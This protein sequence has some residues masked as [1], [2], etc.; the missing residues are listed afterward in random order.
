MDTRKLLSTTI[1]Y[2]VADVIVMAVGGFLLLPLYTRA[3]SQAEFGIYVIVRANIEIFTY[4]LYLGL[5]SAVSRLYFDYKKKNQHIE[6]LSSV[7]MFFL[8]NLVVF[9]VVLSVWGARLWTMLSPATP[10]EPYLS[11]CLAIAAV[12]FFATLGALW[13]RMESRVTAFAGLQVGT[14]VV[15]AT[16]AVINLVVLD[17][18]LPGLLFALLI[19]S[20]CSALVLPWL[21]GR[22]FRPM[23]RWAHITESLHY[24]VPIVIGYV[25]YFVLNRVSTLIL[26]RHV[27]VDQVAIFGLAQQLAMSVSIASAALGKAIQP[28]VFGAEPRHA[29]VLL[30]KASLV[31]I[32]LMFTLTCLILL[33]SSDIVALAAPRSYQGL[34]EILLIL[35]A[36][37]FIYTLSLISDTALL[38]YRRPRISA[39]VSITGAGV[40][41]ILGLWLVPIHGIWGAAFAMAGAFCA[42]TV[43]G[44]VLAYRI[45]GIAYLRPLLLAC[46]GVC[47]IAVFA[48]WV[49]RLD[50]S[51]AASFGIRSAV[52]M[53]I[54]G[55]LFLIYSRK[56]IF[57]LQTE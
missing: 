41:A 56:R 24:A 28:A 13:L 16:T 12:G 32:G 52:G 15:L 57:K 18:G 38:Y 33:F 34:H 47:L 26:Q 9:G 36:A 46:C 27:A 1:L 50:I 51:A 7:L 53:S 6:Y 21:F 8:L 45:T 39:S 49:Q 48:A 40:S 35:V 25:A 22:R 37:T 30:R 20:A 31:L 55:A 5:P 14:S 23:I 2:G 17:K 19:S 11:F 4:L 29:K 10:V 43:L 42:H 44:Y 54:V 3:L